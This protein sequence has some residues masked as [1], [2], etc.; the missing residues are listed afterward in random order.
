MR[1]GFAGDAGAFAKDDVKDTREEVGD[2]LLRGCLVLVAG[3]R[4][5]IPA[6]FERCEQFGN[7]LVRARVVAVVRVII[8][9][10]VRAHAENRLLIFLSLRQGTLDQFVYAVSHQ[11]RVLLDR[12]G[13]ITASLQRVVAGVAQII[14]R[15]EKS[16]V[17]IEDGHLRFRIYYFF[18]YHCSKVL[19]VAKVADVAEVTHTLADGGDGMFG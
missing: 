3:Y 9:N 6:G 15:I 10:E 12:M 17:Q 8:R 11:P 4:Q 13:G 18:L 14:D 1:I 7:A 2:D 16:A 19:Y 5:F